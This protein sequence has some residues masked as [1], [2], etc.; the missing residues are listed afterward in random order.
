MPAKI[1]EISLTTVTEHTG[2]RGRKQTTEEA[3]CLKTAGGNIYLKKSAVE[4]AGN[5]WRCWCVGS[6]I[7][8]QK[9]TFR[10]L[11]LFNPAPCIAP[12]RFWTVRRDGAFLSF[13][14][15]AFYFPTLFHF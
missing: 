3:V 13:P 7:S 8:L 9:R 15:W 11:I 1:Q 10:F 14:V 6:R 2:F 12:S 4:G 5:S